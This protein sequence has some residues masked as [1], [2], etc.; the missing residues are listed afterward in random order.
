MMGL[1]FAA[2]VGALCV[3]APVLA[4]NRAPLVLAAASLQESMTAAA[5]AWAKKG[6]PRP[7]ISFAA[8]SALARQV[9]AG[10]KADLFASADEEWMDVLQKGGLLADKTRSAFLGN[11]LV[12]IAPAGKGGQV[13]TRT[14]GRTLS[15]GPLAMADTD[16]V[17]AGK[18]GKAALEKLGAWTM[19]APHV[20][21]AENVRAALALVER[22][23]APYGIV[24]ATDA[25][26]SSRVRVAGM[27][28]AAS[29][30]PITYPL[31][32]LKASTNPEGE[33]FRRFLLSGEGKAIFRRYGFTTR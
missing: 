23:A 29:H 28:P 22:G 8:S 32:R 26:A 18:Y 12:L 31:A 17:P 27:F 7:V 6:H 24:Y 3:S 25:K 16:S 10:G 13:T 1:R 21:R 19:V 9:Q 20:V 14:L 11:R 4:Q 2:L 15:A 30:P 5:D 33:G